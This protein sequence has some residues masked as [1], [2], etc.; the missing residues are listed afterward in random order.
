VVSKHSSSPTCL[1]TH[2]LMPRLVAL[3]LEVEV[4]VQSVLAALADGREH[5]AHVE[6]SPALL[7]NAERRLLEHWLVLVCAPWGISRLA[8]APCLFFSNDGCRL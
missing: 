3:G 1:S 5:D 8:H 6:L 2:D 7:L 4:V